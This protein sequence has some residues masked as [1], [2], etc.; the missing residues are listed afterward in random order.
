MVVTMPKYDGDFHDGGNILYLG[1][2]SFGLE[3]HVL[4]HTEV[5]PSNQ[6]DS[7]LGRF[8]V[9]LIESSDEEVVL[10]FKR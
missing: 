9:E 1:R 7:R 8:H 2:S 5:I 6:K 10:D 4:D 3:F